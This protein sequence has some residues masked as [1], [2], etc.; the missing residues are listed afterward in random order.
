MLDVEELQLGILFF[1]LHDV[2]ANQ[3]VIYFLITE[4]ISGVLK[5]RQNWIVPETRTHYTR[6]C[7]AERS[8]MASSTIILRPRV[9][10]C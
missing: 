5:F 8:R 7:I 4:F 6:L 10:H 3:A 2:S 1:G 9:P